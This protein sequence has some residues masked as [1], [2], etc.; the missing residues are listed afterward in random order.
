M[1]IYEINKLLSSENKSKLIAH[2]WDCSCQDH[3]LT[4]MVDKLGISQSNL[5]KHI[6][7]LLKLGILK[8]KQVL[9]ER[10][11]YIN[12]KWKSEW[13]DIVEPQILARENK[14]FVCNCS[15]KGT[16]HDNI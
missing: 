12:T 1:T 11:Y 9:K 14:H 16:K 5:S 6:G 13:Q 10:Y 15:L 8:Y 2:F 3:N 4:Y 7:M